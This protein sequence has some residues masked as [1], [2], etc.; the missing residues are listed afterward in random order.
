MFSK[1]GSTVA[2]VIFYVVLAFVII[3][4]A[5]AIYDTVQGSS[6]FGEALTNSINTASGIFMNILGPLF[7]TLL[8]SKGGDANRFLMAL[9]F[10]LISIIIVGTLDSV[11]ILGEDKN[12]KLANFAIGIIVAIIGVRF[13]PDDMWLSLTAPSSAF[14]ATILVG[15]PFAALAFVTMKIHFNLARKLL[16]LF[17]MIFLS[18]LIFFS[19]VSSNAFV[20]IYIIFLILAGGMMVF[21]AS[22]IRYVRKEK[23]AAEL[24]KGLST[25]IIKD[26]LKIERRIKELIDLKSDARGTS[27]KGLEEEIKRLT[28]EH[29]KLGE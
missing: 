21:D 14:V 9:T 22:V 1:R 7:D 6:D 20:R 24:E 12:A 18:Y 13:M 16:W 15:I 11:N 26:R 25:E 4:L 19:E 23:A 27:K 5:I 28:D 29:K 10:I 8:G 17:Y 3:V 2:K